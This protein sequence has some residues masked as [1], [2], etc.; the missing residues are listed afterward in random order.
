MQ[1]LHEFVSEPSACAYL[2]RYSASMH[3][4]LALSLTAQEYE[5]LMNQGYRKFGSIFFKPVCQACNACRSLRVPLSTFKPDRS[6]RRALKD[7]TD[8]ELRFA[9]ASVDDERL[10][11]YRRYHAAQAARK[12]WPNEGTGV[13]DY[14]GSFVL[15][16][17]PNVEVS[18]WK[19]GKL[20]GVMLSDVTPH[21]ISD[22]YHY[23]DP[24]LKERG[25]GTFL[26]MQTFELAKRLQKDY[27]Y[28]GYYVAGCASMEYKTRFRPCEVLVEGR[29]RN[30]NS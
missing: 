8:L 17:V 10:D 28:L 21:T 7:N 4:S 30:V 3:Y 29:W 18:A 12:Q 9:S 27:V 11:L 6:Q 20:V 14:A 2:P 5:D 13:D 16:P 15:N 26:I 23:H 24:E 1:V 19:D 22:I 25:L